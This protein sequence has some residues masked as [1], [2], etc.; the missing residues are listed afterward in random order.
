MPAVGSGNAAAH[1]PITA[2]LSQPLQ[3]QQVPSASGGSAAVG[4]LWAAL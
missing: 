3:E 2:L 1:V 4:I